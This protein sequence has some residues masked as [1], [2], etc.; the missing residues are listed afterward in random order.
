VTTSAFSISIYCYFTFQLSSQPDS[1]KVFDFLF[2]SV[3]LKD[4]SSLL[5]EFYS[6]EFIVFAQDPLTQNK[7]LG[8]LIELKP[9]KK[10]QMLENIRKV[11]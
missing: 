9:E 3:K 2:A 11:R 8:E 4:Q 10:Q 1:A 6:P 7:T 5:S